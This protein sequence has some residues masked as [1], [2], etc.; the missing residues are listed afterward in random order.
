[1]S[2]EGEENLKR[3]SE[4]FEKI[5]KI[6]P[7]FVATQ[8]RIIINR[9]I[10]KKLNF[11]G[12]IISDDICMKALKGDLLLNAKKCLLSGCN[13]VLYCGGN[14]KHSSLLLKGINKIDKFT[15]KK[16]QQFY[17]FLR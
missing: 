14:T 7:N 9:I 16:T 4:I 5:E 1:M 8:S 13:L 17:E 12:L 11:K 2:K 15:V 10:R 3:A 6:D